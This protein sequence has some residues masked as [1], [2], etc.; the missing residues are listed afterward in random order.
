MHTS[1]YVG[2]RRQTSA[3][4]RIRVEE[5]A[6]CCGPGHIYI[7]THKHIQTYI[8][9][10]SS[11]ASHTISALV[12]EFAGGVAAVRRTLKVLVYAAFSYSLVCEFAGGV[13]AERRTLPLPPCRHSSGG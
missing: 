3:Y 5:L 12:C 13:A 9:A 6:S 7:H 1:A 10:E 11:K 2:K 4:V 8:V